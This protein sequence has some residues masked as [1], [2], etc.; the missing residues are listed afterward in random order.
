MF[1]TVSFGWAIAHSDHSYCTYP[2]LQNLHAETCSRESNRASSTI[3]GGF[4]RYGCYMI[5]KHTILMGAVQHSFA[6]WF[7]DAVI[8]E[9]LQSESCPS[10]SSIP[11]TS[12]SPNHAARCTPVICLDLLVWFRPGGSRSARVTL[13]SASFHIVRRREDDMLSFYR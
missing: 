10:L 2:I 9:S 5:S 3:H 1:W 7:E 11:T 6:S 4:F 8:G 13:R 12:V